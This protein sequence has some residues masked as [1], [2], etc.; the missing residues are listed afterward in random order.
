VAAGGG[1]G[2]LVTP[3]GYLLTNQH[4]VHG[5]ARVQIGLIDGESV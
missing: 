4:V 2:V 3:D 5:A 1:S